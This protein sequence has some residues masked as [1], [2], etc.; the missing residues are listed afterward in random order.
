MRKKIWGN[1]FAFPLRKRER[2]KISRFSFVI[3][4]CADGTMPLCAN[5]IVCSTNPAL[6][7]IPLLGVGGVTVCQEGVKMAAVGE[8]KIC[9]PTSPEKLLNPEMIGRTL[10]ESLNIF[11]GNTIRH[12]NMTYPKK[13]FSNY[14]PITVSRFRLLRINF[15]KLPDIPI[16][17]VWVVW[18]YPVGTPVLVELFFITVTRFEIFR[19]NWVMFSWQMVFPKNLSRQKTALKVTFTFWG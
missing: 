8:F 17:F 12:E 1:L 18:H 9:T 13:I 2:N 7:E 3:V 5:F 11:R 10:K 6:L 16:A 14:F 19:I 15:R 4:F